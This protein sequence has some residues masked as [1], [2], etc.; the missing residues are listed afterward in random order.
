[1]KPGV[2]HYNERIESG[3]ELLVNAES[4]EM[5]SDFSEW[6]LKLHALKYLELMKDKLYEL[7]SFDPLLYYCP[8]TPINFEEPLRSTQPEKILKNIPLVIQETHTVQQCI[9]DLVNEVDCKILKYEYDLKQ[10][11]EQ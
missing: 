11:G 10:L 1:M 9:R 3:P 4:I 7:Q 8:G 2:Q 6:E 5:V